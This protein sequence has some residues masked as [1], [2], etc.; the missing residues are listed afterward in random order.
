LSTPLPSENTT[1]RLLEPYLIIDATTLNE[2]NKAAAAIAAQLGLPEQACHS[3][4]LLWDLQAGD[5]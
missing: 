3:F 4:D 1:Q 5:L 2:A